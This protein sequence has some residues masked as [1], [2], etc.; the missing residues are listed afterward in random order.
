MGEV[1]DIHTLFI[2]WGKMPWNGHFVI[3]LL[4]NSNLLT[5]L[6]AFLHRTGIDV[7]IT[8]F[9]DFRQFS[10]IFDNFRRKNDAFS[11]SNVMIIF[12]HNL[13]LF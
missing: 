2:Q 5:S 7:M 12:L 6:T 8:I 3:A 4:T 10:A 9:G 11:E 13:A 1:L